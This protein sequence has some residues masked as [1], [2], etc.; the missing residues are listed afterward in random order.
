MRFGGRDLLGLS[1]AEWRAVRG[2]EIGL[3]F[4]EPASALDPVQTIGGQILEALHLHFDLTRAEAR[5]R[6]LAALR[7]APPPGSGRSGG[8]APRGSGRPIVCT[9][10][11]AEA[12]S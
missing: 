6:A 3:V 4:Q 5:R 10:S 2:R 11:S 12:G 8:G 9:G 7:R 1:D